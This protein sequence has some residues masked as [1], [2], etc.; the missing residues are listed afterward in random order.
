MEKRQK[1]PP[2]AGVGVE[3]LVGREGLEPSTR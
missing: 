2:H 1:I 3:L